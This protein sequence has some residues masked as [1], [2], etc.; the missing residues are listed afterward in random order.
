MPIAHDAEQRTFVHLSRQ[1]RL[2]QAQRRSAAVGDRDQGF[3]IDIA[4][5]QR[6]LLGLIGA[7]ALVFAVTATL[8]RGGNVIIPTFALERTQELLYYLREGV[9]NGILPPTLPI[10]LDSPMASKAFCNGCT[11]KGME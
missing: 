5:Q 2:G 9:E 11:T 8:A 7:G 4:N 6:L 10:Y 3:D 1:L